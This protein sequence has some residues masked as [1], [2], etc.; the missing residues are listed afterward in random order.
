MKEYIDVRKTPTKYRIEL[1]LKHTF[2]MTAQELL[3]IYNWC[4]E[5]LDELKSEAKDEKLREIEILYGLKV[6]PNEQRRGKKE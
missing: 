1:P 5:N 3:M 2:F 6:I 4:A